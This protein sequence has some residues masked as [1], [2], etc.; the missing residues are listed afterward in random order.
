MQGEGGDRANMVCARVLA[1]TLVRGMGRR[2]KE[3]KG[4]ERCDIIN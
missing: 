4:K 1:C 2:E 3:R